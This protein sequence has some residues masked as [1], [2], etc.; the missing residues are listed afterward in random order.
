MRSSAVLAEAHR[1]AGAHAHLFTTAPRW[2]FAESLAAFTYHDVTVDVGFRQKSALTIDP[3][4]TVEALQALVP[5]DPGLVERLATDVVEAGCSAV[6]CDIAPL[7]VAV[8]ERAG[9][10]SVLV[11]NFSW[12]WL[13][14]PL[15]PE[16]SEL[17]AAGADL[18]ADCHDDVATAKR[19]GGHSGSGC[20]A[21]HGPLAD[22]ADDP[23]SVVPELPRPDDVCLTC[24]LQNVAK[25]PEFPQIDP[26]QHGEGEPCS[27]C[28]DPHVPL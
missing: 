17:V 13:Y 11:E 26:Q 25:P 21:C 5:F 10:P 9:L 6:L 4:R 7:G 8:A 28:H 2:F 20:E 22:H 12:P 1:R 16:A 19:D 3:E 18:C 14:E 24:H 27:M 15:V 23:G